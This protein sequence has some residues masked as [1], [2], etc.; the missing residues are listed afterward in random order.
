MSTSDADIFWVVRW[1]ASVVAT[2][3]KSLAEATRAASV[4]PHGAAVYRAPDATA[5]R[6]A[7]GDY[8]GPIEFA[9]DQLGYGPLAS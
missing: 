4:S 5:L 9:S 3:Y 2:P 8:Y 6:R 7:M 1:P